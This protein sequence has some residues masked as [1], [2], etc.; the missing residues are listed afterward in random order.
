[1]I[2]YCTIYDYQLTMNLIELQQLEHQ[3][4]DASIAL[5][6]KDNKGKYLNVN[7]FMSS[8]EHLGREQFIDQTDSALWGAQAPLFSIN[9]ETVRCQNRKGSYIETKISESHLQIFLSCK[10]PL[11]S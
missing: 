1:M 10:I 11:H 2:K 9:D 8:I 4:E 3:Y 6:S 7:P 5:Y